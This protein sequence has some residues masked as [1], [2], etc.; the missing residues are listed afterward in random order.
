[1]PL[2]LETPQIG[3]NQV[4]SRPVPVLSLKVASLILFAY[5]AFMSAWISDDAFITLRTV[6]NFVS[7]HGLT[8]NA[9]ERVQTYTH[10]L[11]MFFLSL[12]YAI[13]REPFFTGI[14]VG[15]SVSVAAVY[16]VAFRI[17]RTASGAVAAVALLA[18]SKAFIDYSTSGLENPMSHFLLA[19]FLVIYLGGRNTE[20][21][22]PENNL[23]FFWV[24]L[25]G[26]LC[27][28]NRM[29]CLLLVGPTLLWLVIDSPRPARLG[30]IAAGFVPFWFWEIFSVFYYGFPFPNTA[31]AKLNTGIF[32]SLLFEQGFYYFRNSLAT[33]PLTVPLILVGIGLPFAT[34]NQRLRP[35]AVGMSLYLLYIISVGGDFMSGRLFS[36]PFFCAAAMMSRLNLRSTRVWLPLALMIVSLGLFAPNSPWRSGPGY[37]LDRD[38]LVDAHKIADERGYYFQRLGLYRA[39]GFRGLDRDL[40][41]AKGRAARA[42]GPHVVMGGNIGVFGFHAGPEVHVLDGFALADPL[43]ARL[44]IRST[45]WRIGHFVRRLPDGYFKSLQTNRISIEDSRLRHFANAIRVITRGPLTA[46]A[47]LTEIWRLNTGAYDETLAPFFASH[48][49]NQR[50][51]RAIAQGEVDQAIAELEAAVALDRTRSEAWF[52]LSQLYQQV[53]RLPEAEQA[54]VTA[55]QLHRGRYENQLSIL[56]DQYRAAGDVDKARYLNESAFTAHVQLGRWYEDNGHVAAAIEQY[57][58]ALHLQVGNRAVRER[59]QALRR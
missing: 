53:R 37:G 25:V 49:H 33:D 1:M 6:D 35:I 19:V 30:A 34:R 55:I 58:K 16:L 36:V 59:L 57:E 45:N 24:S 13:T 3:H 31:Y 40:E 21:L 51:I 46:A 11:W 56:A 10:P 50:G 5:V 26:C 43:L 29:D 15:L 27:V 4:N 7:G 23:R 54:L 8:W 20:D 41:A 12:F 32:K 47:R 52:E 9:A 14:L 42:K 22:N 2:D 17:A 18:T 39:A 38:G 44:P 48:R 28:L